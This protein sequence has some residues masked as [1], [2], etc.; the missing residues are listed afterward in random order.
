MAAEW[1]MTIQ[2]AQEADRDLQ[3]H[4]ETCPELVHKR[5]GLIRLIDRIGDRIVIPEKITWKV[6]DN[7]HKF[8]IHFGTDKVL[9]FA[10]K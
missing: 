1:T 4:V 3:D 6:I 7:I 10:K 8:L 5:D 9:A 2:K